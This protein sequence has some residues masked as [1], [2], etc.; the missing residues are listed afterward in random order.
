LTKLSLTDRRNM[1]GRLTLELTNKRSPLTETEKLKLRSYR[2]EMDELESDISF[3]YQRRYRTAFA[4]NLRGFA[5]SEE[6]DRIIRSQQALITEIEKRDM[7]IGI[8]G[9]AYPSAPIT[10]GLFVPLE[11][12]DFIT[13]GMKEVGPMFRLSTVFDTSSGALRMYPQEDDATIAGERVAEG[14]S[15]NLQ[16]I[17]QINQVALSSYQYTSKMIKVSTSLVQD[18]GLDIEQYLAERFSTRIARIA[19]TDFTLGT[20][21]Q[22]PTG[23]VTAASSAGTAT[24]ASDNDGISGL[25]SLAVADFS[26]LEA[27][28]DPEYRRNATWQ[29]HQNTLAKLRSQLDKQGRPL[30]PGLHSGGQDTIFNYPIATNPNMAQLQAAASSPP[31]SNVTLAFGDW[32]KYVIRRAPMILVMLKQ[33]FIAEGQYAYILWQRMDG[34]LIDGSAGA[35]KTLQNVY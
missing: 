18:Y 25:N 34:N 5:L 12:A 22:Q 24:G 7:N 10:G 31:I 1:L 17:A 21:I 4:K 30:F 2:A 9:G 26:A 19:N 28:V 32:R 14:Q 20:G 23:F 29:M 16:D 6:E 13:S 33:R 8:L 35:I 27:S 15:S 11:M 3:E